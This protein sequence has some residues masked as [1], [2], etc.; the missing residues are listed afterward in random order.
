MVAG[1][2]F[3]CRHIGHVAYAVIKQGMYWSEWTVL[4]DYIASFDA[5][6]G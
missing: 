2:L 4:A 1:S 6:K 3:S 5:N